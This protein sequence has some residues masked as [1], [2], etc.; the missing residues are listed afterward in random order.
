MKKQNH[1]LIVLLLLSVCS[2]LSL[3]KSQKEYTLKGLDDFE[4]LSEYQS[5]IDELANEGRGGKKK[6]PLEMNKLRKS[7]RLGED[8]KI[9]K[10]RVGL[11]PVIGDTKVTSKGNGQITLINNSEAG[12]RVGIDW[13]NIVE[14]IG[15]EFYLK[16][17]GS[18]FIGSSLSLN[19]SSIAIPDN[20]LLGGEIFYSKKI[21][22]YSRYGLKIA[23]DE[24]LNV[25]G[26]LKTNKES[27]TKGSLDYSRILIGDKKLG[28]YSAMEAGLG[29]MS[30]IP[31]IGFALG[32]K[33]GVTIKDKRNSYD[34]FSGISAENYSSTTSSY[35]IRR[36]VFGVSIRLD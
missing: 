13:T 14:T 31:N 21:N 29:K 1:K 5:Y 25:D 8:E 7:P 15:S 3:A 24:V 11:T 20:N 18:K 9:S 30:V 4:T 22:A 32:L 26:Q 28:L 2:P 34:I 10:F 6:S 33:V 19:A 35:Q 12:L 36:L 16:R 17:I 23:R 27:I